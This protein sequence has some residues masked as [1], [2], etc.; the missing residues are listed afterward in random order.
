MV[1]RSTFWWMLYPSPQKF[2]TLQGTRWKIPYL[3]LT[4]FK[5]VNF[6]TLNCHSSYCLKCTYLFQLLLLFAGEATSRTRYGTVDGAIDSGYNAADSLIEF[7]KSHDKRAPAISASNFEAPTRHLTHKT[8]YSFYQ[9]IINKS[10]NDCL[11]FV[12][13]TNK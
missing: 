11:I 3:R 4:W 6:S 12:V 2:T 1:Q 8:F 9:F 7:Y 5:I 10:I 13:E